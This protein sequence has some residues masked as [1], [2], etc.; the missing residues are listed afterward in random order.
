MGVS[1]R[2]RSARPRGHWGRSGGSARTSPSSV[3]TVSSPEPPTET[4]VGIHVSCG[5]WYQTLAPF[6]KE[7]MLRG[8]WPRPPSLA[9]SIS[10][11][12]LKRQC[13]VS[14][15][16][17]WSSGPAALAWLLAKSFG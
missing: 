16:G 6:S 2:L 17:Q 15:L 10:P 5:W 8:R 13:E 1:R 12:P 9:H 7:A 14:S 3:L 11:E 4:V